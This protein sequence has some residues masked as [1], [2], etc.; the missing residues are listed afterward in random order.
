ME[1]D[2]FVHAKGVFDRIESLN[3][4]GISGVKVYDSGKPGPTIGFLAMIHGNEPCGLAAFEFLES[5]TNFRQGKVIFAIGNIHAARK[6]F[7]EPDQDKRFLY[8]YL[9]NNLN[10]VPRDFKPTTPELIRFQQ[11]KKLFSSTSVVF[12]FHSTS[13]P[14]GKMLIPNSLLGSAPDLMVDYIICGIMRLMRCNTFVEHLSWKSVQGAVVECGVH[15]FV[16]TWKFVSNSTSKILTHYNI[17]D[18][19]DTNDLSNEVK[20]IPQF[21]EVVNSVWFPKDSY[22]MV[23]DFN[24]FEPV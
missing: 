4:C 2:I 18:S 5:Q 16:S 10:R 21:I 8:R 24:N 20:V 13:L 17:L 12:D 14:R 6:Y 7:D 9:D 23:K 19:S 15:E 1:S 11:L 3:F 22:Q